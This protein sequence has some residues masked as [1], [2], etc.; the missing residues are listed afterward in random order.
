MVAALMPEL[1]WHT[2]GPALGDGTGLLRRIRKRSEL[3]HP[4]QFSHQK[5]LSLFNDV[6]RNAPHGLTTSW[7]VA[8][9]VC[10]RQRTTQL[11]SFLFNEN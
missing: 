5:P 4:G 6:A 2:P 10:H 3:S 11:L 8:C 1:M 9:V 7:V